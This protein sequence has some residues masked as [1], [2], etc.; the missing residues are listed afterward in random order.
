MYVMEG[1]RKQ[2][3]AS[4]WIDVSVLKIGIPGKSGM[5]LYCNNSSAEDILGF[6]RRRWQRRAF[7]EKLLN[8]NTCTT[9]PQTDTGDQLE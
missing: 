6:G 8:L 3:V 4:Y 9:V 5:L 2:V 7:Q 1:R